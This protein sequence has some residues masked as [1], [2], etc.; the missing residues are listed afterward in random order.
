MKVSFAED[1]LNDPK[2]WRKLDAIVDHFLEQRHVWDID[3]SGQIEASR[4]MQ[5][6]LDNPIGI[7][8]LDAFH[9][10]DTNA[11]YQKTAGRMHSMAV[12]V[13]LQAGSIGN[14]TPDEAKRCLAAPAYVVV[15]NADSDGAFLIAM[16][17]AFNHKALLEAHT[18][19]WWKID[20]RGG[21]TEISKNVEQLRKET[22]G[23]LR[24]FVL[25]DSDG[26]YPGD[27]KKDIR[28]LEEYCQDENVPYAVLQKREI[29]NY[30]P[31]NVLQ[32]IPGR[33]ECYLA[34]LNITQEQ[35]DHYD[36]KSG[37]KKDEQNHAIVPQEQ[38]SLFEHVPQKILDDLCEGFGRKA[39]EHFEKAQD[40]ITKEAIELICPGNTAEIENILNRI[41]SLL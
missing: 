6:N 21:A 9:K 4:W 38:Q 33:R 2:S 32:G 14:V 18:E 25:T 36:M 30:L 11:I 41:E 22:F 1:V 3:S 17:H 5:E 19:V 31:V 39:W 26:L 16:L 24:V 29:E 7:E 35:R 37:F 8:N 28:K 20:S 15:E 34:F 13:T 23:P 27:V 10:C 12:C 40:K